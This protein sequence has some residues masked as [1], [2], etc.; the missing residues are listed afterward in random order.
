MFVYLDTETTGLRNDDEIVEIAVVD[1]AGKPILDT[2]IKPNTKEEWPDAQR[3]HKIS[4][5]MV[6]ASPTLADIEQDL[7][8]AVSGRQLVIYNAAYD[9]QYL[10]GSVISATGAIYCAMERYARTAGQWNEKQASWKW[11]RLV[12]A[13]EFFHYQWKGEPHRAM[14]DALATGHIWRS[15]E[16]RRHWPW[17]YTKAKQIKDIR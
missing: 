7:I 17:L 1:D 4:P 12:D 3:L 9:C 10:P 5:A 8:K 11:H 15:L 14:A 16:D 2:T 13:A 6:I